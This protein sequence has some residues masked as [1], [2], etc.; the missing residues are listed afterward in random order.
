[1]TS[2]EVKN[3][4]T[5]VGELQ[6]RLPP[7]PPHLQTPLA[8]AEAG[9][10]PTSNALSF[11]SSLVVVNA[12]ANVSWRIVHNLTFAVKKHQDGATKSNFWV[13]FTPPPQICES[14]SDLSIGK[15]LMNR[16]LICISS[17]QIVDANDANNTIVI[18][19][20]VPDKLTLQ[21]TMYLIFWTVAHL[22]PIL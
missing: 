19:S 9:L 3:V 18:V 1:M 5:R 8:Q 14:K 13:V 2:S 16:L 17:S 11:Y 15:L 20:K 6:P 10:P 21:L 22:V 12:P 7:P 4:W